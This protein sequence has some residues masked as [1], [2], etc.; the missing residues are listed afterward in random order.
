MLKDRMILTECLN[1]CCRISMNG[2]TNES[3]ATV[4]RF[5]ATLRLQLYIDGVESNQDLVYERRRFGNNL[6]HNGPECAHS[7][8]FISFGCNH[9]RIE[10]KV[11]GHGREHSSGPNQPVPCRAFC[12]KSI[13]TRM[14]EADP[15]IGPPLV[16][17]FLAIALQCQRIIELI[18][19]MDPQLPAF[20]GDSAYREMF[21][22]TGNPMIESTTSSMYVLK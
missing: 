10:T 9:G 14:Q 11:C 22:R 18:Q 16:G 2:R 12:L 17:V 5:G 7:C 1:T 3:D 21:C 8:I 6:G 19:A 4:D 13:D 20:L 15:R